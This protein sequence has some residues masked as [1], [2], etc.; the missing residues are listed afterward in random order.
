MSID[1]LN[2]SDLAFLIGNG[3][4]R[5]PADPQNRSW[6][7]LLKNI[8]NDLT[9]DYISEIP[10][11][12]HLTEFYELILLKQKS[13]KNKKNKLKDLRGLFLD[14]L[15]NWDVNSNHYLKI[16]DS[17]KELN[18][19]VMTTNFDD[20]LEKTTNSSISWTMKDRSKG[21]TSYYPWESYYS[22]D[23]KNNP[24]QNFSI[25][26]I[27]GQKY[28]KN[29]LKLGVRHY[30]KMIERARK[31]LP[32]SNPKNTAKKYFK[33][34]LRLFFEKD[35]FIFGLGLS[36]QELFLRWILLERERYFR[37]NPQKRKRGW[38]VFIE[39]IDD[40]NPGKKFYLDRLGFEYKIFPTKKSFYEDFW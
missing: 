17:I 10:K 8:Y 26:H 39:E 3:I 9:D 20:L 13:G 29:S 28:Y 31:W 24:F 30:L 15:D 5:Y 37:R 7:S 4:N 25:W 1:S 14:Y 36:E 35:L 38:Y 16:M 11:G 2:Y 6:N 19:P 21:F 40:K 34:W 33:T 18:V 12:I 32:S 22:D 23:Y 27:Q